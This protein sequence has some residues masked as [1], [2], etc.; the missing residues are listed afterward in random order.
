MDAARAV[1]AFAINPVHHLLVFVLRTGNKIGIGIVAA[2]AFKSYFAR[3]AGVGSIFESGREIPLAFLG[4]KCQG[5]L[6][7]VAIGAED[8]RIRVLART[9]DVGNFFDPVVDGVLFFESEFPDIIVVS[10]PEGMVIEIAGFVINDGMRIKFGRSFRATGRIKALPHAGSLETLVDLHVALLAGIDTHIVCGIVVSEPGIRLLPSTPLWYQE[11]RRLNG[12]E[13]WR[14]NRQAG[15][16]FISAK[17]NEQSDQSQ[18]QKQKGIFNPDA[19][20]SV[21]I[22]IFHSLFLPDNRTNKPV[23]ILIIS[24]FGL[25]ITVYVRLK[26]AHR[27]AVSTRKSVTVFF[28]LFPPGG[29]REQVLRT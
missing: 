21:K 14:R 7:Q 26:P 24:R 18:N 16:V 15:F 3:E 27:I 25:K 19:H 9:D 5:H 12:V 8:V 22:R 17:G 2:H 1:A 11:R 10:S 6:V 23:Y 28:H 13:T 29:F 20:I 4:I